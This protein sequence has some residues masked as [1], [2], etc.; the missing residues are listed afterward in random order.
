[1]HF[2]FVC[3][4]FCVGV[5]FLNFVYLGGWRGICARWGCSVLDLLSLNYLCL[6][7]VVDEPKW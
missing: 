1:M 6:S 7:Q 5:N 3:S 2:S 4:Y